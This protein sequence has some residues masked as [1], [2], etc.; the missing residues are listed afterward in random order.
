MHEISFFTK[1]TLQEYI[2]SVILINKTLHL[3]P[4]YVQIRS[5]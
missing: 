3:L 2:L 4:D 5:K 1:Q